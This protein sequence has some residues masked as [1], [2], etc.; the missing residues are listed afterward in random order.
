MT[1]LLLNSIVLGIV[2]L[3]SV[4]LLARTPRNARPRWS[5]VLFAALTL[6]LMTAVFDN[7][8]IS[9]GLV[10]YDP[11][12]HAGMLIGVAP[13]EDFAYSIAI[14]VFAPVFWHYLASR[15]ATQ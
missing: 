10:G 9:V 6:L 13:I 14:A 11:A 4:I 8:M 12:R 15:K 1:Y 7:I 2:G 3:A 5:A